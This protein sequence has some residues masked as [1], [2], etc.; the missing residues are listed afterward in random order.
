[1]FQMGGVGPMFRQLHHYGRY[2]ANGICGL[3]RYQ[4]ET[5]RLYEVLNARLDAPPYLNDD[6]FSANLVPPNSTV[7]ATAVSSS[8][9][10]LWMW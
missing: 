9:Y 7:D 3:A 10:P 1:M 4:A 2:A 8:Y 5:R 6:A